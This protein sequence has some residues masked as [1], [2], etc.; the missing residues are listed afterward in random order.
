V[1]F[2][3]STVLIEQ[4]HA[5]LNLHLEVLNKRSDGYHNLISIMS[6]VALSDLL[7]LENLVVESNS[8]IHIKMNTVTGQYSGI[9]TSMSVS[10]NLIAKA[11][12]KYLER[13]ELGGELVFS[14]EKNIPHGA[15]LGG[16]S[17]DAA[18]MLRILDKKLGILSKEEVLDI[19]KE[20]GADVPFC[21]QGGMALCEGIGE[22]I[23]HIDLKDNDFPHIVIAN[24]GTQVNTGEAYSSLNRDLEIN[25]E[26][27]SK[28]EKLIDCLKGNVENW[29]NTFFNDFESPVF[30]THPHLKDL[31]DEMITCKSDFT[32]MSGSG[33]SI[34]GFFRSLKD[35]NKAVLHFKSQNIGVFLTEFKIY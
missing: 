23:S 24:D 17:A 31:K 13:A 22:I 11:A 7:K 28:K 34:I 9:I 33:S 20:L 26:N 27:M 3:E 15:G 19:A 30:T 6:L 14:I 8:D 2:E 35:A 16:G 12:Q 4:A 32:M 10:D 5:K 18:A 1:I 29:K 21:Y 25:H